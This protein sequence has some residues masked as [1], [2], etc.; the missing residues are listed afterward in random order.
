LKKLDDCRKPMV[1][2]GYEPGSMAYRVYDPTSCRVHV[3]RD[4]IFD[5]GARWN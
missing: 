5:E 4:V 3:S 1:F 2:V